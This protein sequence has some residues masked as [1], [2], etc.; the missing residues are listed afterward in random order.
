MKLNEV[1]NTRGSQL[2][3]FNDYL[4]ALPDDGNTDVLKRFGVKLFKDNFSFEGLNFYKTES[5]GAWK[6]AWEF[7]FPSSA[8]SYIEIQD[9]YVRCMFETN[10]E[11]TSA[12]FDDVLV[13][14]NYVSQPLSNLK[15]YMY[16]HLRPDD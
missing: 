3:Q 15:D 11:G 16:R 8:S 5:E 1:A 6:G 10:I 4:M 7:I 13:V 9:G 14:K 2:M 12:F